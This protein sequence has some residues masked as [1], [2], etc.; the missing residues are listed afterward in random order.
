MKK[1]YLNGAPIPY[2]KP[3]GELRELLFSPNMKNFSLA[4]EALSYSED[5]QAY[6]LLKSFSDHKDKYRRLYV[7]K[8][9]FR[10]PQAVE[11]VY[12]LENALCSDDLSFLKAALDVIAEYKIKIS[13]S[14]LRTSVSKHINKLNYEIYSLDIL[15]ANEENYF[16]LTD[17]FAES[18]DCFKKEIL[19]EILQENYLPERNEELFNLFKQDKYAKI[20]LEAIKLGKKYGFDISEF[21]SDIDGHVRKFASRTDVSLS[22]ISE[23]ADRF[24][25]DISDD[26]ESAIIYNPFGNDNLYV[27]YMSDDEYDPFMVRFSYQHQH[28]PDIQSVKAWIDKIISGDLLAIEFFG[29]GRDC[30]GGEITKEYLEPLTCDSLKQFLSDCGLNLFSISANSFK[31]RGWQGTNDIDGTIVKSNQKICIE[32]PQVF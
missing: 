19:C 5:A 22:F 6:E 15:K 28:L 24:T 27:Y 1:E 7:I 13:E 12:L 18:E 11:L 8:T 10:L 2:D 17:I 16:Y 14:I 21:L 25:V 4:C 31:I 20:R 30:F 9:V 23:Y 3:I 29:D 26:L 32:T